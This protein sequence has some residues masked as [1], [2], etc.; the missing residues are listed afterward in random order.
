MA[1]PTLCPRG[2]LT[3]LIPPY[4]TPRDNEKPLV[5]IDDYKGF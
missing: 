1:V 5:T 2:H 4:V 3:H